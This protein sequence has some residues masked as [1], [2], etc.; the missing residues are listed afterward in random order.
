MTP[1]QA[2]WFLKAHYSSDDL[3]TARI[4]NDQCHWQSVAA[5][6]KRFPKADRAFCAEFDAAASIYL[7]TRT[8]VAR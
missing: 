4:L 6:V 3:D 5:D 8:I 1:E 7:A 2:E